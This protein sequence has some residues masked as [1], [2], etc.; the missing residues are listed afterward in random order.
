M[1]PLRTRDVGAVRHAHDWVPVVWRFHAGAYQRGAF[2]RDP[3]CRAVG[4][5]DSIGEEWGPIRNVGPAQHEF[6][7]RWADKGELGTWP[8]DGPGPLWEHGAGPH[9]SDVL[10]G[11]C[12]EWVVGPK[13]HDLKSTYRGGP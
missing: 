8:G 1:P 4:W 10:A 12:G 6:W 5:L 13:P 3:R 2:C 9:I 7:L 11:R